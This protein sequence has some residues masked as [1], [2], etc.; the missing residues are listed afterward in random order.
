MIPKFKRVKTKYS[1]Y[2]WIVG[3]NENGYD[4]CETFGEALRYWLWH[5]GV[6]SKIA[7]GWFKKK[8]ND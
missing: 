3:T 2:K 1:E 8:K 4:W 5:C 6:P 7:F